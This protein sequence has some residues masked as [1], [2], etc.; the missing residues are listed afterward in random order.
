MLALFPLFFLLL[1]WL[2][3]GRRNASETVFL[4]GVF[5]K[6]SLMFFPGYL[7]IAIFRKIFGFSYS[8]LLLFL[9]LLQRDQL[10]PLLVAIGS[11]LLVKSKLLISGVIEEE[12]FLGVFAFLAGFMSMLSIAD[13]VRTWGNWSASV[14]FLLPLQRLCSVLVVSLAAQRFFP[15][16]GRDAVSI[17][18]IG[19]AL[20]LGFTIP[21]FLFLL[22]RGGWSILLTVLAVTASVFWFAM[23]FPRVVQV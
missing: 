4:V 23:R 11:L 12:N 8:G 6:G 1:I 18:A 9:S 7:V 19:A 21:S 22:S 5:F 3:W 17:L 13:M 14:L 10:V 2:P 20:A 15:W 16:E